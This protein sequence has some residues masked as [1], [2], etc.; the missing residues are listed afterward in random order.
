[1]LT[2]A[3]LKKSVIILNKSEWNN[4]QVITSKR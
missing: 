4:K 2:I 1:M 3:K